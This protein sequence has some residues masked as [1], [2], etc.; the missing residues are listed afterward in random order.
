M[1]FQKTDEFVVLI[2]IVCLFFSIG[3]FQGY[4]AEAEVLPHYNVPKCALMQS[5]AA[6]DPVDFF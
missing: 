4:L 1:Q 6:D 3:L 5:E 2:L